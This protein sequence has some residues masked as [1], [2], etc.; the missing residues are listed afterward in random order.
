MSALTRLIYVTHRAEVGHNRKCLHIQGE[1]FNFYK[2][3][4]SIVDIKFACTIYNY[5]DSLTDIDIEFKY[6]ETHQ[7]LKSHKFKLNQG[8]NNIEI[9]I[10]DMNIDGLKQI[11]EICFV[12]RNEYIMEEEGMFSIQNIQVK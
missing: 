5:T 2:F 1:S 6:H 9:A 4:Q 11:S 12:C 10:K 3:L 8:A 7:L